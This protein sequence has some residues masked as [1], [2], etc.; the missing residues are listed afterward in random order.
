MAKFMRKER[1]KSLKESLYNNTK[2][3]EFQVEGVKINKSLSQLHRR[4][5]ETKNILAKLSQFQKASV[6]KVPPLKSSNKLNMNRREG[7]LSLSKL[8][9]YSRIEERSVSI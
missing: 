1:E 5:S 6:V 3:S 4:K 2:Q 8:K 7:N 9:I